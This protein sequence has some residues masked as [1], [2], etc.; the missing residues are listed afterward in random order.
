MKKEYIFKND[1]ERGST[2]EETGG[3]Y[4]YFDNGR[5]VYKITDKATIDELKKIEGFGDGIKARIYTSYLNFKYRN[6]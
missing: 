2:L 4:D 6:N 3:Y 5:W 1:W